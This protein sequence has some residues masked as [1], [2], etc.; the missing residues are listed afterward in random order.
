M[1]KFNR[2]HKLAIQSLLCFAIAFTGSHFIAP[3][4]AQ[5][6]TSASTKAWNIIHF[7]DNFMG[8]P[9]KYGATTG[10]T[11]SFDCSSF[12]QYVYGKYGIHLPRTSRAQSRYGSY[13]SKSNLKPGDLVFFYS[14][15]HHVAIYIGN[16]KILHTYGKPG[17]TVSRLNAP[18]WKKHYAFAKRVI[19]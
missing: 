16:G 15:V 8:R 2:L 10:N 18:F 17:V 4:Q 5:A 12:V 6:A 13:V 9:Y 1:N 19:H 7:A 3:T 11:R 14:P